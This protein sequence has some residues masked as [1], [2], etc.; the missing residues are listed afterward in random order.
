[1]V[2]DRIRDP[3]VVTRFVSWSKGPQVYGYL[4]LIQFD[5]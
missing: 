1:M 3:H 5:I 2:R 4:V